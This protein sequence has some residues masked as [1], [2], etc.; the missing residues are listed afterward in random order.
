MMII[1]LNRTTTKLQPMEEAISKTELSSTSPNIIDY[2][3]F[4][5]EC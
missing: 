5:N 3:G 1:V 4:V 2:Y